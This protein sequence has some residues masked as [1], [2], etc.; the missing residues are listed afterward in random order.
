MNELGVHLILGLGVLGG[1]L[2]A[3]AFKRFSA[4]QVLG[5]IAA[6]I[7]LGQTG[8]KVVNAE[9]IRQL[10]PFN[11]FTLG[12]IGFLVGAELR[13]D[14]MKKYARQFAGI[15]V[16]E[17]VFAFVLVGIGTGTI[18][19]LVSGSMVAAVAAGVVFGAVASAT[20]PASTISV[21]W[22]YRCAGVLTTTL[23]AIVALDD[24]LALTLYG[25][26]TGVA[27]MV[28]GGG[29]DVF[30]EVSRLALELPGSVLLGIAGGALAVVVL[31]RSHNQE[32]VM[33]AAVGLLLLCIGIGILEGMDIILIAMSFGIT[34]VN[35]A[36]ERSKS[37]VELVRKISPPFYVMFFVLVG[38]RLH[39]GAMPLW[40]WGVVAVYVVFRSTGKF[41]GAWWGAKVMGASATVRRNAGLGL[42]A[43]G[44]VAIGLS[45]MASQRLGNVNITPELSF[46]DALVF[47]V[48]ATTFIVQLLGPPLVKL[49]VKRAGEDG[50]NVTEED[51]ME[52][53]QVSEVPSPDVTMVKVVDNV[54][55]VVN[56]YVGAASSSVAV[57]DNGGAFQGLIGSNEIKNILLE[58]NVWTWVLASDISSYPSV[59]LK[60]DQTVSSALR[61]LSQ[62]GAEEA[63]VVDDTGK[64]T[65][66]LDR[67]TIIKAVRHELVRG[68]MS[69]SA[70]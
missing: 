60:P 68:Q 69:N 43:Q 16:A 42:M 18:V 51:I 55:M 47:V 41:V 19:Y 52:R 67:G 21:L 6:G 63:A 48:T 65:G 2:S 61:I 66:L 30:R 46:A 32:N 49:A 59:T 56:A 23:T 10:Q 15:L 26:G 7:L 12:L 8:F 58:Q 31:R 54:Q 57:V 1:I 17:G 5:Y 14:T 13:A 45:V 27:Q 64:L 70:S 44:G 22:E 29:V 53:L 37:F 39:F 28:T 34:L 3:M 20:D 33:T 24:A 9:A 4:P 40:L 35:S 62:T 50:R 11:L 38:A 25:I 36:P